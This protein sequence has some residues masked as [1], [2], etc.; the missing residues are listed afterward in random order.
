MKIF[1]DTS[2][3]VAA[4]L[5]DH[6]HHEPARRVLLRV[7]KGTD[8]G[9]VAGHSLAEAYSVLTR[10]P[11]A[12]RVP[13]AL[14]WELLARNVVGPFTV[15]TLSGKDYAKCLKDLALHGI[16]GGRVYDGLILAAAEKAGAQRIYT[17]NVGHFQALASASLRAR[18][19]AP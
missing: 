15:V 5:G 3:L 11:G 17:F 6:P 4:C 16:E 10:L 18:V 7:Q 14:V 9:T 8:L 13:G 12:S 1:C 2:V 19:T